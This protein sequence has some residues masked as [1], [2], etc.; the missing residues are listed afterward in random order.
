M[1]HM[2]VSTT[3]PK[4]DEFFDGGFEDGSRVLVI[5]DMLVDKA[6]FG[7]S[8]M[9]SRLKEGDNG[10]YFINNKTPD[11]IKQNI[12]GWQRFSSKMSFIDGI[13]YSLGRKSRESYSIDEKTINVRPYIEKSKKV[14]RNAL[15]SMK[16]YGTTAVF[17]SLDFW[18]GHWSDVERFL[19]DTEKD[20]RDTRTISYYLMANIGFK[21]SNIQRFAKCFDYV[22]WLKAFD[23]KGLVL[24]QLY[25][26]KPRLK[27]AIPFEITPSGISMYIPKILVTGP[28]H[29]GKS[30]VVKALSQRPVSIDRMGTTIA[31]DHG[32][33][34]KKGMSVDL[35]GTPGQERF[36]WTLQMLSKSTLGILLVV[37]STQPDS[38]KRA[39]QMLRK[40]K[41]K[42][43]P[44][45]VLANKQ[46]MKGALS[47]KKIEK[48]LGYPAVGIVAVKNKGTDKALDKL[49]DIVLKRQ[50]WEI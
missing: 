22:I 8:I 36:D 6:M 17:D 33:V 31:L 10:I 12:S 14:F 39:K 15:K 16:G 5:S 27:F 41:S 49:F 35:F 29:A 43:I 4:L 47:P 34:E 45:L 48:E 24:K 37:D 42:G 26:H 13:S 3:I 50:K 30:S 40:I 19:K 32:H 46:D 28:F 7:I 21:P 38:I 2:K 1:S 25:V 11:Y 18:V 9:A 44:V 20:L 23:S